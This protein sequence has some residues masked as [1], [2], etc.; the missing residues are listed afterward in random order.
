[1]AENLLKLHIMRNWLKPRTYDANKGNFGCVAVLGG[2]YGMPGAVRIAG[3][4]ALRI[5][6]GLVRVITRPEHVIA[7]VSTRPELL[8]YGIDKPTTMSVK[9]YLSSTTV[10]VLGPGLGQSLWSE[11]IFDITLA[12]A[13]RHDVPLLID[14]DGLN[15]LIKKQDTWQ[16][17]SSCV[18]TP[19]PGEA[20]R[21]LG[22][23]V[24]EVQANR[25]GAVQAIEARFGGVVVLK[26]AGSLV[27]TKGEDVRLCEAGN[28][29][30]ASAGMGDLL[31]GVIA[32]LMAQGLT[33]W[34]ASQM[35]VLLHAK[36]GDTALNKQDGHALLASD[37]LCELF[38]A[39]E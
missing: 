3:E 10:I 32:G 30:M 35:G 29:A 7:V 11:A 1:M 2:D 13:Y 22:I 5:G 23:S 38:S 17:R 26:G 9:R 31:S 25:A 20:A 34:Q 15:W 6:A 37:L 27:Y 33:P 19:H 18:L 8:C 21:M 39:F 24:D 28:P 4:G 16:I 14:A 36:A 12:H